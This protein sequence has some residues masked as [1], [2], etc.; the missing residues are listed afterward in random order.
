MTNTLKRL[1]ALSVFCIF[2][3]TNVIAQ[4]R[5]TIVGW[6]G[7]FFNYQ[8]F[9]ILTND[10]IARY[11]YANT[12][13]AG[14]IGVSTINTFG[15]VSPSTASDATGDGNQVIFN[16]NPLGHQPANIIGSGW[17]NGNGTK[18]WTFSF[19]STGYN[20]LEFSGK[21]A[22]STTIPN[23]TIDYQ[24]PRDFK[25]QYSLNNSTWI[26]VPNGSVTAANANNTSSINFRTI[27]PVSLPAATANQNTVY[28]R[29]VMT[30]NLDPNGNT[31]NST[32]GISYIDNFLVTGVMAALPVNFDDVNASINGNILNVKWST[33][34]ETNND[35]FN[36]QVSND[37]NYFKNVGQVKSQIVDGN[38]DKKLN[39]SFSI[40]LND[41]AMPV[42]AAA[43]SFMILML[44]MPPR[45]RKVFGLISL[46]AAS[47]FIY[48]CTKQEV[49]VSNENEK[50]WVKIV[51]VDKD[52][53]EKSSRIVQAVKE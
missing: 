28:L 17:M 50:I 26:D 9:R 46:I 23:S 25:L 39:Y 34:S 41:M 1:L 7:N 15:G 19:K 52:G 2:I 27:N 31:I 12:G 5:T 29:M 8:D 24:G 48:S 33:L 20:S 32:Y 22:S 35:H 21:M 3:Q 53:S 45:K 6:D 10:F 49:G 44:I 16:E 38:S 30:S 37:G 18:G 36:I 11:P 42:S 40:N 47:I 4:T 43:A 13:T 51:Q 14:N